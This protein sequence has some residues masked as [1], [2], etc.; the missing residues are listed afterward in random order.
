MFLKKTHYALVIAFLY[1]STLLLGALCA[2]DTPDG[3]AHKVRVHHSLSC[4][5]ACSSMLSQE[6]LP[7]L[8]QFGLPFSGLLYLFMASIRP[9]ARVAILRSRAPPLFS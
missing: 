6:V 5:L 2:A 4:L 9:P 3:H 8:M 7:P 1:A